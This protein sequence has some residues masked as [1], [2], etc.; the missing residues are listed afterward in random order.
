MRMKNKALTMSLQWCLEE[1]IQIN[2]RNGIQNACVFSSRFFLSK[3][4]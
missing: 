2:K 3:K 1:A 4:E